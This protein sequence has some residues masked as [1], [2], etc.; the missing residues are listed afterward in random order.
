MKPVF[1]KTGN[2]W[3][4]RTKG[5]TCESHSPYEAYAGC[6]L[7][8][9][10]KN[11]VNIRYGVYMRLVN[12]A[13]KSSHSPRPKAWLEDEAGRDYSLYLAKIAMFA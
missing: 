13:Y 6:V 1:K 12:A 10:S 4:C 7:S 8:H 9:L 3:S 2:F 11:G 5:I